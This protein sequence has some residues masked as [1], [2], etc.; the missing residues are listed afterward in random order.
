MRMRIQVTKMM[1]IHADPDP[2]AD[3]DPQHCLEVPQ[4]R[5]LHCTREEALAEG[6]ARNT[7]CAEKSLKI[8]H[9]TVSSFREAELE[10]LGDKLE[11]EVVEEQARNVSTEA[12]RDLRNSL[13]LQR[14]R[15]GFT[16]STKML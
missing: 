10:A 6:R 9:A 13:I 15:Q 5:R 8:S 3:M 11:E 14:L 12:L 4:S 2:D 1:R 7:F 16:L